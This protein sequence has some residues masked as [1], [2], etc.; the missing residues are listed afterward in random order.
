MAKSISKF[1]HISRSISRISLLLDINYSFRVVSRVVLALIIFTASGF[2]ILT[3]VNDA[4]R[5][6]GV[7]DQRQLLIDEITKTLQVVEDR[8][9]YAGAWNKL[10]VLY[11]QVGETAL[12][13]DAHE[14][15]K[16]LDPDF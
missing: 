12:A 14:I 11:E 8:P 4:G 10:S 7:S 13:K 15:A 1:P 5:V 6:Q 16:R 9:D 2:V 3:R